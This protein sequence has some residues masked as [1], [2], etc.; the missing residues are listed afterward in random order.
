MRTMAAVWKP[1][2]FATVVAVLSSGCAG[3]GLI[4]WPQ[5]KLVEADAQNPAV[6]VLTIWQPA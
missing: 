1:L 3:V 5:Q 2:F 6:E 4:K